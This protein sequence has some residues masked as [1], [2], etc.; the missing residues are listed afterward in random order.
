MRMVVAG[1]TGFLGQALIAPLVADGHAVISLS[2]SGGAAFRPGGA[3]PGSGLTTVHW[4]G[5]EETEGWGHV[6]DGADVVINLAGES[7]GDR[8]WTAAQKARLRDSRLLTTRALGRALRDATSP[9]SLLVNASAVGI[10]G[11]RGDERLD[12]GA[13]PGAD[14]L[15][16]LGTIWEQAALDAGGMRVPVARLRTGLVL[17]RQGGALPRML[18]PFQAFAGGPLGPGTQY[19]PWIHLDDWVAL[20]RWIVDGRRD[21]IFNLTA[22]APVRNAD[23]ARA[24]G[25]AIHRPSWLP[26][27]AFALRLLLGEMADALLLSGQR[28]VPAR[29]LSEG[30]VFRYETLEPALDAIF[31]TGGSARD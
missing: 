26:A 8:R 2:R 13:A 5:D 15:A 30:F 14:F 21:G 3:W 25:R 9:P 31:Q 10:Y 29:A 20:V 18:P 24:L 17:A 28:A 4:R 27:P 7:I 11:D 22:P 23:F 6:V 19:M 12:E 1:G 16:E